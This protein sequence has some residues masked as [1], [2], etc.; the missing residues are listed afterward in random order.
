M[1]ANPAHPE[2]SIALTK[3]QGL[4]EAEA[5]AR[6][7]TEGYNE[8][9]ASRS[10][11]LL[12][13]VVEV[14]REPMFL[15]LMVTGGVYVLLGDPQEAV[16]LLFA[17]FIIIGITIYQERKTERALQ[18]LRDLSSP[19]ALVIRDG[20][21][22]RIAGREVVR[23][24]LVVLNEGDRVPA[25][26]VIVEARNVE[27]DESLLTGESAPVRKNV[28]VEGDLASHAP[29]G[30]GKPFVY[31]ST[32][33][34]RGKGL[35][36]VTATGSAT[37][38]GKIGKALETLTPETTG[39][40]RET[41]RLVR[42]LAVVGVALC[43]IVALIYGY[44]NADWLRG[45]LAGLTLGISMIPEEFPVVLTIFMALG[46]WRISRRQVLTRRLTAIETLGSAT[47]LCVDKTGTLT[48]NRM[49]IQ[50][51]FAA[52]EL[53]P[54]GQDTRAIQ[55][56][57]RTV[58]ECGVLASSREPVDPM[59]KAI[60]ELGAAVLPELGGMNSWILVREYPLS[61]E[62]M[63][64]TRVWQVDGST[65]YVAASKGAPEAIAQLCELAGIERE[66]VKQAT[67]A[68]ASEGLRVLGVA[69]ARVNGVLPETQSQLQFEFV[70]LLGF[71]DPVRPSAPAA[72]NECYNA[73]VRVIMI[74]GDYPVTAQ[75]IAG[76]IGLRNPHEVLTGAEMEALEEGQLQ[77]RLRT[78]NVCA[79]VAPLEKLRLVKALKAMGEVVAMTGDGVNDAPALKAADIGIAMGARG[80]DVAREAA[81][82]VL[83]DDDFTSIVNAI[84]LG[85]RIYDNLKKATA[86]IL[87][88]HVPIAGVTLIPVLFG[89]PLILFP[90]HVL[91]LELIIDPTCSVAFEAEPE[92]GDLMRRPPR[93]AGERLFSKRRVVLSLLQ[94]LTVLASVLVVYGLALR[95]HDGDTD[96]RALAFTTLISGNLL[97][98]F[99]NRSWSQTIWQTLRAPNKALW[100]VTLSALALLVTILYVPFLRSL[101]QFSMLHPRDL[102]IA[103]SAGFA[104]VLW[105]ELMKL[106][107]SKLLLRI[108]RGT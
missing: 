65:A 25:D 108:E 17:V 14:L 93:D 3:P 16:A 89:W 43:A 59:E 38:V 77:E 90:L 88:I 45:I 67:A 4:T 52:G 94:G 97:L 55:K 7:R 86:Y 18:A 39:L 76:Q 46:A 95:L 74:T 92:E 13:I 5:T 57:S 64:M 105:F 12:H 29:G 23:G 49:S 41:R 58:I 33:I 30:D 103:A 21:R 107:G 1:A 48:M 99:A 56:D 31:S 100:W 61:P 84:R 98:I 50:S 28:F 20:E 91:F 72:V 101:F 37:E 80:T 68:L 15:L 24:D 102:V 85:R 66:K 73:G 11:S 26:A 78:T 96:P 82:L 62:L 87:A 8:L 47:V 83:L 19:R 71:A 63:A 6:L 27:A 10:R 2:Q 35:A 69:R 44:K 54:I 53:H 104:G 40:Q 106:A 9:P 22:K 70:G 79:R 34:V 36:T 51:V 81:S 60:A 32:L 75:N 42:V